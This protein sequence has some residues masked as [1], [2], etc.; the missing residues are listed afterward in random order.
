[1][2][3]RTKPTTDLA[4]LCRALKAPSLARS[5]E[6]LAERARADGWTHEEFLA[7]CLERE[8]AARQSNGGEL[9]IRAAR[10]PG[11]FGVPARLAFGVRR[12]RRR[13]LGSAF[14]GEVEAVGDRVP[15]LAPGDR[16]CGMTGSAMGAHAE[17][18]VVP[19]T[20]LVTVPAG[21][22][23]DDAAGVLFGGTTA[24]NFLRKAAVGPGS[25]VLVNGAVLTD[26]YVAHLWRRHDGFGGAATIALTPVEDPSRYV[27][28]P[29]DAEG[30]VEA[31]I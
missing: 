6:R 11:G 15:D 1:M 8:D 7:A 17:L 3:T 26:L 30:R 4:Y 28:V 20:R 14:S 9:R 12:P 2:A 31:F 19:A 29:I 27:V 5:I 24:W 23:H 18:L 25:T 13:I 21:V 10:F 16:V 22:G